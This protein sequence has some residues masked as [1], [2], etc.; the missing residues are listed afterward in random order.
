MP[1]LRYLIWAWLTIFLLSACSADK[2]DQSQKFYFLE[3]LALIENAGRQLQKPTITADEVKQALAS[4]D[5]G[6][7]LAFQVEAKFLDQFDPRLAKNYQRYFVKGVE[8]YR[9][10]I[11]AS[12]SEEQQEGLKRLSQWAAFWSE[13]QTAI[14]AKLQ[15]Q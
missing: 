8:S 15:A 11:E 14:N 13:A 9:L 7:K 2:P 1:L 4:M 10:G 6:I 5:E 12:D 3:S